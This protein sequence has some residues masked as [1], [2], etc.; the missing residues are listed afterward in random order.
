M[1]LMV[2]TA[3]VI[4]S[5]KSEARDE[6]PTHGEKAAAP[7]VAAPARFAQ[8][9]Q[10]TTLSIDMVPLPGAAS[11]VSMSTTEITWDAYSTFV[12]GLDQP[13][14]DAGA[15]H[16]DGL[17]RPSKPYITMDRGYGTAGYPVISVSLKGAQAFCAWLSAKTGRAYRL[18][19]EVEWEA[20]CRAGDDATPLEQR[21]WFRDN[22]D[23]KTHPVGSKE[24]DALGL[25]DLHGNAAE[26]CLAADGKGVIR[27]GSFRDGAEGVS[28]AARV[29]PTPA[30]NASDPQLPKSVWWLADGGFIGFRVVCD[31]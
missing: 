18:P 30:W 24:P 14:A 28:C 31:G 20:A 6:T 9:I 22:S 4:S 26:W 10:G 7:T 16:A 1:V 27:G 5:C 23:R 12:F 3:A 13:Q 8:T 17:A 11:A 19:S 21:A 29:T 2:V 15:A 25:F